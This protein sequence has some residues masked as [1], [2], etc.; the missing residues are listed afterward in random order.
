MPNFIDRRLNPK[1][2]S[3]GNR[4]RFLTRA[5][6]ELKRTIKDQIKS[7]KIVD[8]DAAH[9]VPMPGRGAGE[10]T[11]RPAAN[12]GNREHVL[13]GNKTFQEG[14]TIKRPG[15]GGQGKGGREGAEDGEGNDA[16]QPWAV[17]AGH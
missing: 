10:P 11:F 13:P 6:E 3:L 12:T 8:V 9:G 1:D 4:Q 14:D 2:K 16:F 5:R 15:G 17:V 7:D